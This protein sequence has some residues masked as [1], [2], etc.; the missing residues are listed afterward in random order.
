[1]GDPF[2][3]TDSVGSDSMQEITSQGN[4]TTHGYV[5]QNKLQQ[6][7]EAIATV[8]ENEK[9]IGGAY[10]DAPHVAIMTKEI[11]VADKHNQ[12][13]GEAKTAHNVSVMSSFIGVKYPKGQTQ[14]EFNRRFVVLG[15]AT[16]KFDPTGQANS[17]SGIS[18]RK[19]GSGSTMN[20]SG[21][22]LMPGDIFGARFPA[23]DEEE[24]KEQYAT[25][26][27]R[28]L[29]NAL[30]RSHKYTAT[31]QKITYDGIMGIFGGVAEHLIVNNAE[32][33]VPTMRNITIASR[34]KGD[35]TDQTAAALKKY[36]CAA[37]L[38]GV[39][40]VLESGLVVPTVPSLLTRREMLVQWETNRAPI[41][42]NQDDSSAIYKHRWV[43]GP[44]NDTELRRI[45]NDIRNAADV[46]AAANVF[47]QAAREWAGR[48]EPIDQTD[49][50]NSSQRKEAHHAIIT[51]LG[52]KFGVAM[53]NEESITDSAGFDI[54][55]EDVG[56]TLAANLRVLIGSI[57]DSLYQ[58]RESLVDFVKKDLPDSTVSRRDSFATPMASGMTVSQQI[59]AVYNEAGMNLA[60]LFGRIFDDNIRLAMGTVTN[61]SRPNNVMHYALG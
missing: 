43:P 53:D 3:E 2:Y 16:S 59:F 24:R 52:V 20:T 60:R 19:G 13:L 58:Q 28:R 54:N 8:K 25:E 56:M 23:V 38:S 22:T 48:F 61:N 57:G 17:A 42:A 30:S 55:T 46:N 21:M 9:V 49:I 36:N 33:H 4:I 31:V 44:A 15:F 29:P 51:A 18:I 11:V 27:S 32:I 40:A 1:M 34:M 47:Q 6:I 14:L 50:V 10:A 39:Q 7:R 37:F 41:I 12:R 35:E 45:I 26:G 5:P